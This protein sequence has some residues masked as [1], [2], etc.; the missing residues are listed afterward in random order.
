MKISFSVDSRPSRGGASGAGVVLA[1]WAAVAGGAR[2][3]WARA[4]M[5]I[6][7]P[8]SSASGADAVGDAE[9][10]LG[11]EVD[12]AELERAQRDLGAALG[13]RRDHHHR[14]RPQPHQPGQEIEA[15]HARHLDVERD[16]VGREFADHLARDQRVAGRADAFHVALAVDDFG[17]QAA[18]QR[19]IVDHHHA[20]LFHPVH[21]QT[22]A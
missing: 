18:H 8:M 1:A 11:D 22:R 19:R 10:R 6:L 17:E 4:A 14:H 3:T 21:P 9:L 20:D 16:H 7:L 15:V 12:R 13:Q 5:R 2:R